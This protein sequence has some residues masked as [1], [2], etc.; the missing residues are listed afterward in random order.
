MSFVNFLNESVDG[1]GGYKFTQNK[2]GSTLVFDIDTGD[3]RNYRMILVGNSSNDYV[4]QFGYAN[5]SRDKIEEIRRGF[6]DTN[7]VINTIVDIMTGFYL[8]SYQINNVIYK[9][10]RNSNK[11]YRLL[12][13]SIFRKE[14]K[15]YFR[16]VEIDDHTNYD[17][18]MYLQIQSNRATGEPLTDEEIK[19]LI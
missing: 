19:S 4:A 8:S 13:E 10:G 11:S 5:N 18:K 9:F 3:M 6:Y 15:N 12:V 2:V 14:L 7:K 16:K 17:T 1:S